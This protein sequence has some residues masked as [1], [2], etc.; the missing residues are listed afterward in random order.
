M[1]LARGVRAPGVLGVLGF[2]AAL[3]VTACNQPTAMNSTI[4]TIPVQFAQAINLPGLQQGLTTSATR[5]DVQVF[6]DSLI[7][8]RLELEDAD[9]M[10]RPEELDSRVTAL[11][12]GTDGTDT[13]TLALGGIHVLFNA[14]TRVHAVA[15]NDDN[16]TPMSG[17]AAF[18]A[19]V[20]ADLAAGRHPGIDARRPAPAKPQGPADGT[21]LATDLDV[22]EAAALPRISLDVDSSN[23]VTNQTP[24]PDGWV[25]VLGIKIALEVST[26][27]TQLQ[28]EDRG[29]QGVEEFAGAVQAADSTK[30]TATLKS[31]TVLKIVAGTEFRSESGDNTVLTSLPA[32]QKALAAGDTVRAEGRGLP[33]TSTP[34]TLAVIRVAFVV[35]TAEEH[36][37]PPGI[38]AFSDTVAAV[39]VANSKFTL[40]S[41]TVVNVVAGTVLV[42][43]H[44]LTLQLASDSLAAH[45]RVHAT[46][47]GLMTIVG[48]PEALDAI[49]VELETGH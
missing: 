7:A 6:D 18:V 31:G 32:V 36:E 1:D 4:S 46:G 3:G 27:V 5:I 19:L 26:G 29:L 49:F 9:D 14:A 13:L 45:V 39:D 20:Q 40:G 43:E 34:E 15:Q 11:A 23:L 38:V 35:K 25:E 48:P 17:V 12:T 8:R 44:G 21:F 2:V 33:I 30:G 10:N 41:G 28:E 37:P 16:D 24:P 42:G 22:D 47:R